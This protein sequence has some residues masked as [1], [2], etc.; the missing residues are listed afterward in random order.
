MTVLH[1]D[2]F[3]LIHGELHAEDVPLVKLAEAVS[4]PAYIYSRRAIETAWNHYA[5]AL[6]DTPNMLCYAV[7]AN[8]NLAILKVLATLGAGFDIVS[9]GELERVLAAG[10][11]A[12]KVV[13]S[14]VGKQDHE[15]RRALEVGIFCF[16]VESTAELD[17]L[18]AIAADMGKKAH[19]SLRVNPDVDAQTHPYISTGLKDN[20]FGIDIAQAE[21]VYR[22]AHALANITVV[23]IDCHI[24]SQLTSLAP[25]LDALDILLVL[26][27]KLAAQGIVLSH[28]DL[29]GGLGV[30]YNNEQPPEASAL[31]QAVR[32]RLGTRKLSLMFEP[33]RSIVANAGILLTRVALLKHTD[34]KNFAVVDAAMNDLIRPALYDSWHDI[35]PVQPRQGDEQVYDVVGPV[36]ETSDFLGKDRSLCLH[37]GDLLAV[38]SAGAYGMV[39]ASNFNTRGRAAEVLVSGSDAD[40]VRRRE[41]ITDQLALEA[42]PGEHPCF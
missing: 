7:K 37:G 16:N 28:L 9:G 18:Q 12:G 20:K 34:H 30:V 24:G 6:A 4:T 22:Y 3:S 26:V 42:L 13:F 15:I 36:C 33:G 38:M 31:V 1:S 40:V 35:Q 39:M 8:S 14:G 27:D 19:I 2:F 32:S 5:V 17:Q 10:G 23:G 21:D 29:G 41:T 11:E 25:Y